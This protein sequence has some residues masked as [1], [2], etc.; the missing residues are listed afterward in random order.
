MAFVLVA[1]LN[2][3]LA[4]LS[5]S[6]DGPSVFE[7][8]GLAGDSQVY[9][10]NVNKNFLAMWEEG[11]VRLKG[12]QDQARNLSFIQDRLNVLEDKVTNSMKWVAIGIKVFKRRQ[13]RLQ[14]L[15][16]KY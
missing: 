6:S 9:K 11:N 13:N 10:E 1:A 8:A 3:D 4:V 2:S 12:V 7:L 15:Q 14:H 16:T 5:S